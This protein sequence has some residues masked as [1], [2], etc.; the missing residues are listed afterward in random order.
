MKILVTGA[1]GMLGT[2]LCALFR[3]NNIEVIEWDLPGN[4]ITDVKRTTSQ[5]KR[6]SPDQIVHLAAYTDVDGCEVAKAKAYSVNVQGTWAVVIGAKEKNIP[7][8]HIS[9]DYVF[10]GEKEKPYL[11]DD[12]T[13]P[14]NYYGLTKV[15]SEEIVKSKLKKFFIVRTSWLFGKSGKN[16]IKTIL[17]IAKEKETIEVVRDQKGSPTYTKDL[18]QAILKVVQSDFFGIYHITN[19]GVCSWFEFAQEIIKQAGLNNKVIAITSDQSKR[20]A[21]RP[22]FSALNNHNYIKIFGT[23]LRPWREALAQYLKESE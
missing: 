3:A 16:F 8:L 5:I 6:L 23:F 2:D 17:N 14:I 15:Q 22:K 1:N 18:A 12:V 13:Y 4:D 21:K 9:T 20:A 11:E 19:S 7:V 10:D